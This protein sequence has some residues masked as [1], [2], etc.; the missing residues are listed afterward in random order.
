M[1]LPLLFGVIKCLV[2]YSVRILTFFIL[3]FLSHFPSFYLYPSGSISLSFFPILSLPL[4]LSPPSL[5]TILTLFFCVFHSFIRLLFFLF[6]FLPLSLFPFSFLLFSFLVYFTLFHFLSLSFPL[7][8]SLS[9]FNS[10]TL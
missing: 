8:N 5:Y 6:F 2:S 10:L 1:S 3:S 7:F 4:S 9:L